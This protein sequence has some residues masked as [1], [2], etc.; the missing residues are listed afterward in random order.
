MTKEIRGKK[1][2]MMKKKKEM[3]ETG[4]DLLQTDGYDITKVKEDTPIGFEESLANIEETEM[5]GSTEDFDNQEITESD[6][7]DNDQEEFEDIKPIEMK[8]SD[9]SED[10]SESE[11]I[12]EE[13]KVEEAK[14]EV[15]PVKADINSMFE[16][17]ASNV[18][19]AK[20]IFAK[21]A[22]MKEQLD[23]KL[24]ELEESKALFEKNKAADIAKITKY[25][26]EVTSKLREKKNELDTQI[27]KL[28]DT[29]AKF[30]QE[31]QKFDVYKKQEFD[32]VKEVKRQQRLEIEAERKELE[33][34]KEKFKVE[35]D[36]IEEQKRQ[37][38]LDRIKYDSDKNELANN[39]LKFNELVSDFTVNMDK[40]NK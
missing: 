39:L 36:N 40:I 26:D 8:I 4:F 2:S 19:E 29:K 21:N 5:G 32:R 25:K 31:K 11:T 13:P 37:L 1:V 22:E 3:S 18:T 17:A 6:F 24:K 20:N 34:L 9:F 38:E 27:E 15:K 14:E 35:R 10:D 33:D 28:K 12:V 30:D 23:S 7:T 16:M